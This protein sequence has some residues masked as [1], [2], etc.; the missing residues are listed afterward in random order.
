VPDAVKVGAEEADT[1]GGEDD[2]VGAEEGTS[3]GFVEGIDDG[4]TNFVG[5]DVGLSDGIV[6]GFEEAVGIEVR[7]QS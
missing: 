6:V 2:K 5:A 4:S 7:P 1:E 3:V